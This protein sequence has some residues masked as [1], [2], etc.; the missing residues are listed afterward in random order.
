MFNMYGRIAVLKNEDGI[1]SLKTS[2][3]KSLVFN[4]LK[5]ENGARFKITQCDNGDALIEVIS[6]VQNMVNPVLLPLNSLLI[7]SSAGNLI[8]DY[9]EDHTLKTMWLDPKP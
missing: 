1:I 9:D 4:N 6:G 5:I 2:D 3:F 7:D 8:I